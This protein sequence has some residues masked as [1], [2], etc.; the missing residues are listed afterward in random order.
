[1]YNVLEKEAAKYQPESDLDIILFRN[2][3]ENTNKSFRN[4]EAWDNF[5]SLAEAIKIGNELETLW[6]NFQSPVAP[7]FVIWKGMKL[8]YYKL[9]FDEREQL[10]DVLKDYE[11]ET[12]PMSKQLIEQYIDLKVT[13]F[14]PRKGLY[15]H[16]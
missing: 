4:L 16:G 11:V 1:M 3:V 14:L 2:E 6:S 12:C 5:E 10:K 13:E 8:H 9:S 15:K 7:S